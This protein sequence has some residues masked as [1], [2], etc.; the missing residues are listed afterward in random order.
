MFIFI[1]IF[2]FHIIAEKL[3]SRNW[4]FLKYTKRTKH[5]FQR[6]TSSADSAEE[7]LIWR[8]GN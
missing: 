5:G 7:Q 6:Y 8:D 4:G 3:K 1:T 2:R